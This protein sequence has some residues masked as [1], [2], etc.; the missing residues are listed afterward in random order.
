MDLLRCI[1][2]FT[3]LAGLV[4]CDPSQQTDFKII[5]QSSS[6]LTVVTYKTDLNGTEV[7]SVNEI[8]QGYDFYILEYYDFP[9]CARDKGGHFIELAAA[10]DSIVISNDLGRLATSTLFD[11]LNWSFTTDHLSRSECSALLEFVLTD[12]EFQ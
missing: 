10:F 9:A 6:D 7:E 11:E 1:S 8:I 4:A 12:D 3:I 2:F 5:N